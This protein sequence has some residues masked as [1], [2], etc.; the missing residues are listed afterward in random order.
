MTIVDS[1]ILYRT[2]SCAC[3]EFPERPQRARRFSDQPPHPFGRVGVAATLPEI[4][5]DGIRES[6]ER[7]VALLFI[8]SGSKTGAVY[9]R[10]KFLGWSELAHVADRDSMRVV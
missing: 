8:A 10:S 3:A 5:R 1:S 4:E 7:R 6:V 2:R 9:G